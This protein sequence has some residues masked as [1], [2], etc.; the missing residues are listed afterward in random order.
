M[1]NH[2]LFNLS[3]N[4][5]VIYYRSLAFLA[6]YFPCARMNSDKNN[7]RKLQSGATFWY[8]DNGEVILERIKYQ[9]PTISSGSSDED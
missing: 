8:N 5:E 7:T 4:L 9:L 6:A 3:M 2:P 1:A